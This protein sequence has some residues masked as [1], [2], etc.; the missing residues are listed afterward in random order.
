MSEKIYRINRILSMA[1]RCFSISKDLSSPEYF[2][3]TKHNEFLRY[4]GYI[5]F[6]TCIIE[7]AK[8]FQEKRHSQ[9][10]NLY[11]FIQDLSS[12][13]GNISSNDIYKWSHNLQRLDI[14]LLDKVNNLRDKLIAHLDN[15]YIETIKK[16]PISFKEIQQLLDV[17]NEIVGELN[18][19]LGTGADEL[20]YKGSP[21]ELKCAFDH[22]GKYRELLDMEKNTNHD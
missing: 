13:E 11:S 2:D 9:R 18:D 19:K 16:Y 14:K 3:L 12:N 1:N 20:E 5:Y 22:L 10:Q 7:I 21:T 6:T 17:A 4:S 15:D 8:L